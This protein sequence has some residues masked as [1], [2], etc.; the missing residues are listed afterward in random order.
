MNNTKFNDYPKFGVWPAQNAFMMTA[1]QF[2][3]D[4]F[5][6]VGGMGSE[7]DQMI[8]NGCPAARFI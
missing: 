6:G 2:G 5:G 3:A 7:R 4:G 1:N 8:A